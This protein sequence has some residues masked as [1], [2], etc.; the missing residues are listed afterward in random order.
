MPVETEAA[1]EFELA[2]DDGSIVRLADLH[3]RKTVLYFYPKDDTPGCIKEACSFRDAIADYRE[4]GIEVF[5]VS[6]DDVASH[7]KFREK[8]GLN[9]RLLADPE[10]QVAE[11]YGVWKQKRNYGRTYMGVER[12]T[13]VIDEQGRI[14][15]IYPKVSPEQH[16]AQILA[17]LDAI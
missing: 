17:D 6:P 7:R 10:H 14:Q 12:T 8:Y 9:F 16:A 13:F 11:R 5:G 3:G 4:R 2:A 15:K 1:P